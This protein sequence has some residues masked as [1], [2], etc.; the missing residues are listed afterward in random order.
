MPLS[1][2]MHDYSLASATSS[3]SFDHKGK[4]PLVS[5]K[6]TICRKRTWRKV[7]AAWEGAPTAA[8][9]LTPGPGIAA[10]ILGGGNTFQT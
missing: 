5:S 7:G 6:L 4:I 8:P 2:N 9:P 10:A 1:Q 3:R